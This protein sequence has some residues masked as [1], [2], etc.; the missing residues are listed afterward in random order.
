M[1]R[2]SL[3]I[4][5][6][7]ASATF[8]RHRAFALDITYSFG[9]SPGY[10]PNISILCTPPTLQLLAPANPPRTYYPLEDLVWQ[11]AFTTPW[12]PCD[13]ISDIAHHAHNLGMPAP[14]RCARGTFQLLPE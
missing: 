9:C 12:C 10:V 3:S 14:V 11:V 4:S 2:K 5:P 8:C 6:V 1:K 7:L 13:L